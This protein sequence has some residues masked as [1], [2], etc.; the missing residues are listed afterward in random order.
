MKKML[1]LM[2]IDWGWIIQ[3][4]HLLAEEMHKYYDVTVVCVRPIIKRWK[5]QKDL[6]E[7][8]KFRVVRYIPFQEKIPCF[9]KLNEYFVKRALQDINE[10]DIVFVGG[11]EWC[12]YLG[13]YKGT[14]LYDCMDDHFAMH[15]DKVEKK[16]ILHD[17]NVLINKSDVIL[18]SSD[19]LKRILETRYY[20]ENVYVIKN[21]LRDMKCYP[22]K[23][24]RKRNRYMLGYIGTVASWMDFASLRACTERLPDIDIHMIG[25][26]SGFETDIE[27]RIYLD[28]MIEHSQLY[29]AIRDYDCLMM[30]FILNDLVLAV[31]PVKLYEYIGFG[32]CIISVYYDE[33]ARFEDFVY[34]YHNTEEFIQLIVELKEQGFNPKY[35]KQQQEAFIKENSW[36]VRGE[37]IHELLQKIKKE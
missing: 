13:Q 3:R 10:F 20:A 31:D 32:Q 9:R 14:I 26:A 11:T 6:S 33:I 19:K 15:N 35:T 7:P 36:K 8:S 17:E 12:Q 16:K 2:S 27:G 22:I 23:K 1:Y 24:T 25:P 34:F 4:P 29:S 28:G 30:P 5:S 21:G 18:A 37:S